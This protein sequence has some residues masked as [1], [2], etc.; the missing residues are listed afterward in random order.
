M[1]PILQALSLIQQKKKRT[2]G[3][4]IGDTQAA[5]GNALAPQPT[6]QDPQ[7]AVTGAMQQA[8]PQSQPVQ[9]SNDY[10]GLC[11]KYAELQTYGK[12]GIFPTAAAAFSAY[13]QTGKTKDV[14]DAKP[15]NLVYFKPAASNQYAGHVGIYL[16]N[17]QMQ[18]ATDNGVKVSDI[19]DW[20]KV[21][22]QVIAG[23]VKP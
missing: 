15:G 22:G 10:A 2:P 12:A 8:N 9:G 1:D 3:E 23:F 4:A 19:S 13:S 20:Q 7:Q 11:Q 14:K 5:L 17:N 6:Q 18:S 21:T 16:G